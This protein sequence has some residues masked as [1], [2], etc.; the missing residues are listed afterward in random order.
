MDFGEALDLF[1]QNLL[2][3]PEFVRA[4]IGEVLF[5]L[6][7]AALGMIGVIKNIKDS[8]PVSSMPKGFRTKNEIGEFCVLPIFLNLCVIAI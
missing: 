7:F 8:L 6:L 4:F 2:F 3:N 5:G 1:V